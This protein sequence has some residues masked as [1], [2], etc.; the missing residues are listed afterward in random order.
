[1]KIVTLI[2][3]TKVNNINLFLL[4][5]IHRRT[6]ICELPRKLVARERTNTKNTVDTKDF[7][8]KRAIV[9][10]TVMMPILAIGRGIESWY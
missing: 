10:A 1:M 3:S 6:D 5:L 2:F 7:R 4:K 9:T 8:I